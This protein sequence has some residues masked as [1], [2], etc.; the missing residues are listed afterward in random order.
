MISNSV[1][2]SLNYF[3]KFNILNLNDFDTSQWLESHVKMLFLK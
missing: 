3:G 1:Q 2:R